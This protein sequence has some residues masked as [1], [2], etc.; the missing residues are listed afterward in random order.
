MQEHNDWL[1][2]YL[3]IHNQNPKLNLSEARIISR[4]SDNFS[5]V[6]MLNKGSIHGIEKNSPIMTEDGLLGIVTEVGLD[7]CKAVTVLDSNTSIGVYTEIGG[8]EGVIE[9]NVN[10]RKQGLCKMSY[11][12]VDSN[13]Q[14]DDRIY[15]K[16]GK[17]SSYPSGLLIGSISSIETDE[18]TGEMIAIVTP[19]VDFTHLNSISQVMIVTSSKAGGSN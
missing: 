10:L 9:N 3:N 12:N 7:W 5:T 19:A 6:I 18:I 4:E 17:D 16:G 2:G 11:I 1:N 15:T 13:L 8:A 14:R